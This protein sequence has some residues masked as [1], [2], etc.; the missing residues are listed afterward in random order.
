MEANISIETIHHMMVSESMITQEG[1]SAFVNDNVRVAKGLL[2][3]KK[4]TWDTPHTYIHI[5]IYIFHIIYHYLTF[6]SH[7][8]LNV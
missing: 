4:R 7:L 1:V 3:K 5:Y 6:L 2:W 8:R